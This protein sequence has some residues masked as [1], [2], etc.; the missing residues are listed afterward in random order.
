MFFSDLN[1][2]VGFCLFFCFLFLLLHAK[3]THKINVFKSRQSAQN[4]GNASL[5]TTNRI[6]SASFG[7]KMSTKLIDFKVK[8]SDFGTA[9]YIGKYKLGQI[10]PKTELLKQFSISSYNLKNAI[11]DIE[12]GN[13]NNNDDNGLGFSLNDSLNNFSLNSSME[14]ITN[15]NNNNNNSHTPRNAPKTKAPPIPAQ[16]NAA[17]SRSRF[18]QRFAKFSLNKQEFSFGFLFFLWN[19]CVCLNCID[20]LCLLYK[21]IC[22]SDVESSNEGTNRSGIN[23]VHGNQ[24]SGS[25][26]DSMFN[27]FGGSNKDNVHNS[28]NVST[29][30]NSKSQSSHTGN[31]YVPFDL[32]NN[33]SQSTKLSILFL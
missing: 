7:D 11:V 6:R 18:M 30:R 15:N 24:H 25:L 19:V 9:K 14:H 29:K 31:S 5:A 33:F 10:N 23:V 32:A 2:S 21:Y 20:V 26:L 17:A 16:Q 12:N 3:N 8:I 4:T 27:T 22:S 13:Y 1:V 28:N